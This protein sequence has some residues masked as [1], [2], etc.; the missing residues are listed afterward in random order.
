MATESERPFEQLALE[1]QKAAVDIAVALTVLGTRIPSL[2]KA[3]SDSVATEFIGCYKLVPNVAKYAIRELGVGLYRQN[4]EFKVH[5]SGNM[6]TTEFRP[7]EGT[8]G[9]GQIII[10]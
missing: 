3:F 1:H 10:Q 4:W 6:L 7:I 5:K 2:S 8:E 9:D